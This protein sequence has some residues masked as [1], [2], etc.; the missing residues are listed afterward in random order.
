MVP[1]N[2][3]KAFPKKN[4]QM[5]P[6]YCWNVAKMCSGPMTDPKCT[7]DEFLYC[8]ST[9]SQSQS[10]DQPNAIPMKTMHI[11]PSGVITFKVYLDCDYDALKVKNKGKLYKTLLQQLKQTIAYEASLPND[12]VHAAPA[13]GEPGVLEVSIIPKDEEQGSELLE[14]FSHPKEIQL[15]QKA[16]NKNLRLIPGIK[17]A[18]PLPN[19]VKSV[20]TP[21]EKVCPQSFCPAGDLKMRSHGKHSF[22][23]ASGGKQFGQLQKKYFTLESCQEAC[24]KDDNCYGI[25]YEYML[26]VKNC[27]LWMQPIDFCSVVPASRGVD[28][29]KSFFE[30]YSKCDRANSPL[31]PISM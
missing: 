25:E 3:K 22:C 29:M 4:R 28:D 12:D 15:I 18:C 8:S 23:Q 9:Q 31:A 27:E 6:R 2:L 24:L 21:M 11:H 5:A 19:T 16:L 14:Q 30:C 17:L 1:N 7:A 20:S 10:E 26:G 13:S